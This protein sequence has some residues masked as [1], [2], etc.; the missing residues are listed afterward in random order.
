MLPLKIKLISDSGGGVRGVIETVSKSINEGTFIYHLCFVALSSLHD[1][2]RRNEGEETK[3]TDRNVEAL[4]LKKQL[5][6]CL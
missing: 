1:S 6:S 2:N 3:I 5:S 4:L